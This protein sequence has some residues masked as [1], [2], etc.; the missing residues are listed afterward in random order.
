MCPVRVLGAPSTLGSHLVLLLYR[1][2]R[3]LLDGLWCNQRERRRVGAV[4][5][6]AR[7]EHGMGDIQ[8]LWQGVT[9]FRRGRELEQMQM[10][11]V[12]TVNCETGSFFAGSAIAV[13]SSTK[14][15]SIFSSST[16]M[17]GM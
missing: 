17:S 13:R 11:I 3:P 9:K 10:R 1:R 5:V 12:P 15:Q 2:P 6:T 14:V 7:P 16:L 8:A 4:T